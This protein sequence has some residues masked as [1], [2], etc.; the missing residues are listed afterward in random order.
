MRTIVL[1]TLLTVGVAACLLPA[2]RATRIDPLLVTR[3]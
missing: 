3:E 2:G 1:I